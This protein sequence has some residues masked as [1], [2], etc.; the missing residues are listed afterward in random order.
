[1]MKEAEAVRV[2]E[3]AK[4]SLLEEFKTEDSI[5]RGASREDVTAHVEVGMSEIQGN[6]NDKRMR[7]YVTDSLCSL[8]GIR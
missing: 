5:I 2:Y 3:I 6:L 8:Y 4:Q 1:M 7:E